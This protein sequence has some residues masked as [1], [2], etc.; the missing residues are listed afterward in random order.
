MKSFNLNSQTQLNTVQ[1]TLP[2][3]KYSIA[4]AVATGISYWMFTFA[5]SICVPN[6]FIAILFLPKSSR[7]GQLDDEINRWFVSLPHTR[8]SPQV[9]GKQGKKTCLVMV[10]KFILAR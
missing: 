3:S 2:K 6:N 7:K 8:H 4:S 1:N 9:A 5:L 10:E